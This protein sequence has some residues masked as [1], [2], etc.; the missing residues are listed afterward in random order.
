MSRW[1]RTFI[2]VVLALGVGQIA[3]AQQ[4]PSQLEFALQALSDQVGEP[5][6]VEDLDG[7]QWNQTNYPDT[8][9]GCPQPGQVYSQAVTS[10]YQFVLVYQGQTYDYRVSE[11]GSTVI[12]VRRRSLARPSSSRRLRRTVISSRP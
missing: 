12:L 10:G 7:W 11:D 2:V 6:T 5:V 1:L 4:G 9:L 8:S 3:L